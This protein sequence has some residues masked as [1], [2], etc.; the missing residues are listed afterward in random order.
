MPKIHL[1]IKFYNS[2]TGRKQVFKPLNNHTAKIYTCGPTV[3][4]FAHLGNLRT[5][6]FE[7]ILR[8]TIKLSGLRILHVMNITDIDDKIIKAVIQSGK[9]LEEVTLPFEKR[10]FEDTAKLNI[11]KPEKTPRATEHIKEIIA[12][13]KKLIKSGYAY[14]ERDGSVY[15]SIAKFKNYGK[16][17]H[18][19]LSGQRSAARTSA[20]EYEKNE[21]KDFALWKTA[22]S[23]EPSWDSPWGRG[24]PGWHIECSAM[25]MK[26]LGDTLDIHAGGVDNMF[27]HHDNEIAQS[28]AVTGKIFSRFFMHGEHLLV[29]GAKMAKSAGNF[30]ILGDLEAKGYSPL[31]FR[32]LCLQTHYRAKMNF[33]WESLESAKKTLENIKQIARSAKNESQNRRNSIKSPQN[34]TIKVP[35]Q[36]LKAEKEMFSALSDDL[37][38]PRVLAVLWKT[39]KN[40]ATP[41]KDKITMI[42]FADRALGLD[43]YNSLN[44]VHTGTIIPSEIKDMADKRE[45][46]RLSNN[47]IASDKIRI[48]I[49]KKGYEIIDTSTGYKLIKNKI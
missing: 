20:D 25:A 13:N 4:N 19:D 34:I 7:D 47:Y 8:R 15:F 40:K 45:T 26:Y 6:I 36:K 9:T 28:E 48:A 33:T 43:V 44:I 10:F 32:Y 29:D 38:T 17:S 49:E 27:P 46:L 2:L 11:E 41:A 5:Y 23:G 31:A 30:Y 21:A 42:K 16:L 37:N 24:R 12:L 1:P 18:P 22:K 39:L 14:V 35:N 3:Y